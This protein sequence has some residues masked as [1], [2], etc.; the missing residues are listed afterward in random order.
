MWALG[1]GL[2]SRF[3][4]FG[5]LDIPTILA[6]AESLQDKT[7]NMLSWIGLEFHIHPLTI[8]PLLSVPGCHGKVCA[9]AL[10]CMVAV[11]DGGSHAGL[12]SHPCGHDGERRSLLV[13]SIEPFDRPVPPAMMFTAVIGGATALFAAM[14]SMTQSD[15]KKNLAYS[16]ISQIGF[17]IMSCGIGAFVAAIFHLLAHGCLKA[18]LFLSTGNALQSV[19]AN[20]HSADDHELPSSPNYAIYVG[21]L[22]LA[23]IPPFL[24]F[25]GPYEH[26]WFAHGFV[27]ARIMFWVVGLLTV[28]FTAVY[29]FRGMLAL[30]ETGPLGG[31]PHYDR[32]LDDAPRV[33]SPSH[34]VFALIA[35]GIMIAI[36]VEIWSW[37]TKFLSPILS[38]TPVPLEGGSVL[39]VFPLWLGIP[40]GVAV[41]GWAYA[42]FQQKSGHH[43]KK[44]EALWKNALYVLLLNKGY[45]DEIYD[46]AVVRPTVRFSHWL[47]RVI[48]VRW[49]DSAVNNIAVYSVA[50]AEW[51]WRVV[52]VKGIDRVVMGIGEQSLGFGR[53]LWKVVD[54]RWLEYNVDQA[55]K[56][57]DSAGQFLSDSEPRTLQ[58]QLLVMVFW[59]VSAIGLLY[60]LV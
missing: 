44:R 15:I 34:L 5:T 37:M 39:T 12:G 24:I 25:S 60:I 52:D 30:F 40:L 54:I 57:A 45:F 14:V 8:I 53:W 16:T 23:C 50:L 13:G 42:V 19:H 1:S 9:I 11:C 48:D 43:R 29:V 4:T 2:F 6:Q 17:M 26:L 46:Y 21:A 51:L 35:G 56:Q 36:L 47:L 27:S 32:M 20:Q 59:L 31:H 22:I 58:H 18:F 7:I 38:S 10:S 3:W 55:A 49:I 28:F 33:F 41:G